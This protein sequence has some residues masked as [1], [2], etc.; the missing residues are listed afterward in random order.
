MKIGCRL[1]VVGGPVVGD[2]S[3]KWRM[4]WGDLRFVQQ[5]ALSGC[6]L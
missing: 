6:S 5:M 4:L 3:Q 1:P 2:G